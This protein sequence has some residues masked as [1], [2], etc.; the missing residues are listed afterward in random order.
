MYTECMDML[1]SGSGSP[2][3]SGSLIASCSGGIKVWSSVG[4]GRLNSELAMVKLDLE[5]EN[6]PCR[7]DAASALNEDV[8]LEASE[9]TM[10]QISRFTV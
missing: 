8:T 1:G 9:T 6:V 4:K 3:G 7:R 10:K 5:E 2:D